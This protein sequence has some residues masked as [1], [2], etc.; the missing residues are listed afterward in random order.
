MDALFQLLLGNDEDLSLSCAECLQVIVRLVRN[1]QENAPIIAYL[2][3]HLVP[4]LTQIERCISR[5]N[6]DQ[7]EIYLQLILAFTAKSLHIFTKNPTTHALEFLKRLAQL[8]RLTALQ[9]FSCFDEFKQFWEKLLSE[10][11]R[12]AAASM[13]YSYQDS[14]P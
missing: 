9:D 2:G 13:P 10:A 6:L 4:L 8:T 5:E 12:L 11:N 1:E 7:A 3:T 14:N